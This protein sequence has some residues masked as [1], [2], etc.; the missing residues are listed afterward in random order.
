MKDRSSLEERVRQLERELEDLKALLGV[1]NGRHRHQ[2]G[3]VLTAPIYREKGD[4]NQSLRE[5][6][7]DQF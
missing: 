4:P 2:P 6:E 1:G 7:R 5:A 3:P